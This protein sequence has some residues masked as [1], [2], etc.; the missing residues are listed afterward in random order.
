[1]QPVLRFVSP[2]ADGADQAG[3]D[4][5][6]DLG[7]ALD[8]PLPFTVEECRQDL[9][10]TESQVL[11]DSLVSQANVFELD[12]ARASGSVAYEAA[13][14]VTLHQSDV[15]IA[16][17]DGRS[18]L[19][20]GGTEHTVRQACLAGIPVIR[21]DETGEGPWLIQTRQSRQ[22]DDDALSLQGPCTPAD[23][24]GM[25]ETLLRP[26]NLKEPGYARHNPELERFLR[27]RWQARNPWFA[28][29]LLQRMLT[30][31]RG[32]RRSF[33]A[34]P[35]EADVTAAWKHSFW[36]KIEPAGM[37]GAELP[38]PQLK[39]I[40]EAVEGRFAWA[41][42]LAVHMGQVYRSSYIFVFSFGALA[43][44]CALLPIIAPIKPVSTILEL[45]AIGGA[46]AIV[47]LGEKRHWHRRWMEYRL[48]AEQLRSLRLLG[49]IGAAPSIRRRS[50]GV[51]G[52]DVAFNW[53][54]WYVTAT[55]RE[56]R[57]P[58]G[59]AHGTYLKRVASVLQEEIAEQCAF[60]RVN[61]ERQLAIEKGLDLLG[62]RLF[63]LAAVILVGYLGYTGVS[64]AL[65]ASDHGHGDGLTVSHAVTFLSA[66]LPT[67]GSAL[68]A[69][70]AQGDFDESARLSQDMLARLEPIG[71][72]IDRQG[73]LT[74]ESV[75]RLVEATVD[76]LFADL[77]GWRL[78]Y[79]GKPL[80]LPG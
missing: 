63:S 67:L 74:F 19:G 57:L 34:K 28:Y 64:M 9:P 38:S 10:D 39:G 52:C 79:R 61:A 48:L 20:R 11:F 40:S 26:P 68:F 31:W 78:I 4:V 21:F 15:L 33:N 69:I 1:M 62:Q 36:Q 17:W 29:P 23:I 6:R 77:S 13:S 16:V 44:L 3:A 18:G 8:A 37:P 56:V 46:V 66:L 71:L 75:S 7:F 24:A 50:T 41:D 65:T 27:E 2:L 14:L 35:T 5:A 53:I 76:A 54:E 12:I 49:A 80:T 60:H 70:R 72:A 25:V 47:Y 45:I 22:I 43:V 59:R 73:D 58:M 55:A 42:H 32:F 30:S 51:D